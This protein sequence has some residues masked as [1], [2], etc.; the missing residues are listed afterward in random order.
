MSKYGGYTREE[1]EEDDGSIPS[2]VLIDY[3]NNESEQDRENDRASS[4]M[5][6]N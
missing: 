2:S 4:E 6:W 1:I 5:D 3:L